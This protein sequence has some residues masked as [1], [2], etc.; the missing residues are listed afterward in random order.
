MAGGVVEQVDQHPLEV[1]RIN[2]DHRIRLHIDGHL[3][4]VFIEDVWS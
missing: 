2:V 3:G 1:S 4:V